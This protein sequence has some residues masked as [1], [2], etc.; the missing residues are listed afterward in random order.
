MGLRYPTHFVKDTEW[1]GH[2][3]VSWLKDGDEYEHSCQS[4]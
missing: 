4:S 2:P 3:E 1:M